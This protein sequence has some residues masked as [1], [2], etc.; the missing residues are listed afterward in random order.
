[1]R[2]R[3]WWHRAPRSVGPQHVTF[4]VPDLRVGGAERHA[5]TLLAGLDRFRFSPSAVC[6][7]EEGQ[8]FPTLA[9]AGVAARALHRT[10]RQ[11]LLALVELVGHLHRTKPDV[12]LVRGYSAETLGRIAAFLT[13][14]PAT[15]VWVQ[16]GAGLEERGRL[17]NLVD[18]LLE[19]LTTAF[20]AVSQAAV[21]YL[22]DDLG[23]PAG[24]VR[25]IPNGVEPAAFA[26]GPGSKPD[27]AATASLGLATRDPVVG[28]VAVL[29]P[30]KDHATLLRAMRLV[31]D[32]LPTARL[33][34]VGDG[35]LRVELQRL[36]VE[37]GI[38]D[39]AVFAGSRDDVGAL[40]GLMDV[41]VLSSTTEGLPIALLE[42][43]AAGLPTV[44]TAVGGVPEVV[45]DG[46]TGLL[47]PAGDAS[48]MADAILDLLH[49]ENRAREMGALGQAKVQA[50]YSLSTSTRAAERM[51]D[52]LTGHS[53]AVRPL[54]LTFILDFAMVGGAEV[55][56]L[57]VLKHFDRAVVAPRLLCL[58]EAGSLGEEA[59]AAGIPVDVLGR[60]G[61]FDPLTV[62]R[63]I[64]AFR[65][66]RTDV[67]L[68]S[69]HHRAS[70]MLGRVAARLAGVPANIIAPQTFN[71]NGVPCFPRYAVET[72]FLSSAL[73][74][75]APSHG[76]Y[77]HREEGVGR[78]PWR[79]IPEVVIPNGI[80]LAA[81][82]SSADRSAVR[83]DLGID[84]GDV[85]VG[86]VARL[87]A[88]KAHD[89]LLNAIA[90][91]DP[92]RSRLTLIVVGGG[93]REAELRTLAEDLGIAGQ[94]R[95]TGL[96][97]DVARL[98]A[99]FDIFCLCSA[100]ECQPV[101]VLEAMA[102]A[103]PVVAT[104]CGALRDTVADGEEGYIVPVGDHVALAERISLLASDPA[105]RAR[106][107]ARARARAEREY[108]IEETARRFARLVTSL[109]SSR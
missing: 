6:I 40:L 17:R 67:V 33:L 94:V 47:V 102:A 104:D 76:R 92:G 71:N 84:P 99:A 5:T 109:V 37:L 78:F 41:F 1:M 29:R 43:M 49:D 12:V 48:A 66:D 85:V 108:G 31:H 58:R 22:T 53:S 61:R 86:I 89:V 45:A 82:P 24:K 16:N 87:S 69:N 11:F 9:A 70:L 95:F 56:Y 50:E 77:L 68:V 107:G 74:L 83:A 23:C 42:A 34:L 103:L 39:R 90:R 36:A 101:A 64:R 38:A 98:L 20:V 2:V 21:P 57:N 106:L 8:L 4:V 73:V 100:Y 18:R 54:R 75:T 79:R 10:K 13:R 105:L 80:E 19:P 62:P 88:E 51:F 59:R 14:V 7:G 52:D 91:L 93:P 30:E 25:V 3:H 55:L 72:L 63:L 65:R 27:L 26:V 28:I 44:C 46:E 96:R 15:V 97:R 32:R 60:G 35:P 81:L